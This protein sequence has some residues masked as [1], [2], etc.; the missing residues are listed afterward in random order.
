M[1]VNSHIGLKVNNLSPEQNPSLIDGCIEVHEY[2][3][4]MI[5]KADTKHI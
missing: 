2:G 5:V 4:M 3:L 1:S